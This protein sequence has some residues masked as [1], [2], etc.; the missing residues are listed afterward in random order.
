MHHHRLRIVFLGGC[1]QFGLNSTAFDT[2]R[3]IVVVDCGAM[4]PSEDM[5]GVDL[6]LP[7]LEYLRENR[8]RICAYL[9]THGHEDHI[10]AMPFALEVAPAPVYG[11][12]F[13]LELLKLKLQDYGAAA[14]AEM[15]PV[16]PGEPI[17]ICDGVRVTP[18]SMAH[19]IP[20]NLAYLLETPGGTVL[21]SGDFKMDATDTP[22]D[23]STDRELLARIGDQGVDL[24]VADSTNA[25]VPG[26][27]PSE[28]AVGGTLEE[29]FATAPGRLYVAT[30]SS[31]IARI[32][33]ICDLCHAHDRH[34]FVDGR[35]VLKTT[36]V[37]R[38]L[39]LLRIRPGVLV[40]DP[41]ALASAPR[42]HSVV[43][44]S[45]SQAEPR[46]SLSRLALG[47]HAHFHVEP[48]DTVV[49]SARV[50]PGRERH[51]SRLVDRLCRL[52][53][54]VEDKDRG[55]MVHVSGHGAQQDLAELLE[56]VRP[57]YFMPVHGRF[58]MQLTHGDLARRRGVDGV[59]VPNTGSAYVLGPDGLRYD[60]QI[61]AGQVFVE[62][63][64]W[65]EVGLPQ[66]RDRRALAHTGLVVAVIILDSESRT[67]MREPELI[68]RGLLSPETEV[69]ILAEAKREVQSA[70]DRLAHGALAEP[71][72]VS[73]VVRTTLRR[74]F[75]RHFARAPV[76]LPLVVDI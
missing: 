5:P 71:D 29:I 43:L 64:E 53:A 40:T 32:Q 67:I 69:D 18:I 47:D 52:G 62:G 73:Q 75:R 48:G 61:P 66:L 27:T 26:R 60:G 14:G 22:A 24:L 55:H 51:V 63:L 20:Q 34:L 44:M 54:T 11:S 33:T 49:L 12:R 38:D 74:Y 2:G 65:E 36:Q 21:H 57:R 4:F 56:L 17:E 42:R 3:D 31:H 41:D 10:G 68:G 76:V 50:I 39:G 28:D 19:S 7:N 59:V 15:V 13:S 8:D 35:S 45:G 16:E 6:V 9:V 1:G 30:F 25:L 70:I 23:P 46:S 72:E 37:A 58:R